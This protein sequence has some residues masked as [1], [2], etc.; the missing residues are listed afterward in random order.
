MRKMLFFLFVIIS[1]GL[2]F[3]APEY[4]SKKY[5]QIETL[6]FLFF[7]IVFLKRKIK[8]LGVLNFDS[9][10]LLSFFLINFIHASFIYPNDSFIVSFTYPYNEK[11]I[12]Y[13]TSVSLAS[14]A[15]YMLGSVLLESKSENVIKTIKTNNNCVKKA[16]IISLCCGLGIS[17]YV[18]VILRGISGIVHLYPRVLVVIIASISV[19]FIYTL[20]LN[21]STSKS[22]MYFVKI[23]KLNIISMVLFMASILFLGGRDFVIFLS[24]FV[25]CLMNVF[26]Y[27]VPFKYFVVIASI[28]FLFMGTMT[29]TRI[30]EVNFRTA[31]LWD[32][33]LYGYN[34]ISKSDEGFSLLL[35]DFVINARNLYDGIDYTTNHSLLLGAT[36]LQYLF[37]F[38]PFGGSLATEFL[39]GKTM[40]EVHTA[41]IITQYNNASFG[42]GTNMISDLYMNFSFVGTIIIMFLFGM[43]VSKLEKC[44]S[45]Y[46]CISYLTLVAYSLYIPRASIFC[47]LD[48]FAYIV[49]EDLLIRYFFSAKKIT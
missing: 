46:Q 16:S 28:G 35:T 3:G 37:V 9:L 40:E 19:S 8:K 24:L 43:L 12:T 45:R 33:M 38:I 14:I 34:Y 26:Y 48:L 32:V 20:S 6:L 29:F 42:L 22:I 36:Y 5:C 47:W 4:Y 49:I 13:A 39:L 23:N 7:T 1:L 41:S 30:S 10:F 11:I 18:F 25:I 17:F 2:V 21:N 27:R 15:V 44:N 31:S